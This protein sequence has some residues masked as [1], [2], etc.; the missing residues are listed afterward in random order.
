MFACPVQAFYYDEEL[1]SL[2]IDQSVC[3]GDGNCVNWC[4]H[5]AIHQVVGNSDDTASGQRTLFCYPNPMVSELNIKYSLPKGT[6]GRIEIFN[7]RGQVIQSYDATAQHIENLLWN[8]KDDR[9][10]PVAQG[11]Y[12]I[13]L[14]YGTD[15]KTMMITKVR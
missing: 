7:I 5:G 2:Q 3:N 8:G 6:S 14:R 9:G 12:C 13:R 11:K 4:P 10:N 1:Q 15:V